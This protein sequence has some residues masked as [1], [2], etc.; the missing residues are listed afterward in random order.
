MFGISSPIG[1]GLTGGKTDRLIKMANLNPQYD[2]IGK[3]FVT[4]YYQ[5]FDD[6]NQRGGLSALYNVSHFKISA[7]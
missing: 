7:Q 3:A 6:P 5:M 1:L 4:Q 2:E